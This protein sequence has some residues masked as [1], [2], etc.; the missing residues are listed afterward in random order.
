MAKKIVNKRLV[1]YKKYKGYEF[2]IKLRNY[3]L[4]RG[5]ESYMVDILIKG[6]LN[7]EE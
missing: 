5:Y 4:Q 7:E 3:L 6:D 2:K 1:H